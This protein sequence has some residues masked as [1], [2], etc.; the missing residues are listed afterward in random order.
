MFF[1]TPRSL[2]L[3]TLLTLT[4]TTLTLTTLTLPTHGATCNAGNP[5]SQPNPPTQ[6]MSPPFTS[7]MCFANLESPPF[8]PPPFPSVAAST[9]TSYSAHGYPTL[10]PTAGT[11]AGFFTPTANPFPSI[12]YFPNIVGSTS[13]TS[14]VSFFSSSYSGLCAAADT[15]ANGFRDLLYVTS[16]SSSQLFASFN[17]QGFAS[18]PPPPG[19][20]AFNLYDPNQ[21]PSPPPQPTGTVI[22]L[23]IVG[24]GSVANAVRD[25]VTD[26][27]LDRDTN[28]DL[29]VLGLLSGP[30]AIFNTA[31]SGILPSSPGKQAVRLLAPLGMGGISLNGS[32]APPSDLAYSAMAAGNANNDMIVDLFLASTPSSHPHS[33]LLFLGTPTPPS[34]PHAS[35]VPYSLAPPLVIAPTKDQTLSTISL[36]RVVFLDLNND[37]V[38]DFVT[39]SPPATYTSLPSSLPPIVTQ[40]RPPSSAHNPANYA[41]IYEMNRISSSASIPTLGPVSSPGSRL[42]LLARIGNDLAQYYLNP[43]NGR[44]SSGRVASGWTSP[45]SPSP[46]GGGPPSFFNTYL[47]S[48]DTNGDGGIDYITRTSD[49]GPPAG[50]FPGFQSLSLQYPQRFDFGSTV[51]IESFSSS[52]NDIKVVDLNSDAFLDILYVRYN[53]LYLARGTESGTFLSPLSVTLDGLTIIPRVPE[54]L[55]MDGDGRLDLVSV[56]TSASPTTLSVWKPLVP[57][58]TVYARTLFTVPYDVDSVRLADVDGDTLPDLV[59]FS[60]LDTPFPTLSWISSPYISSPGTPLAGHNVSASLSPAALSALASLPANIDAFQDIHPLPDIETGITSFVVTTTTSDDVHVVSFVFNKLG[61]VNV[62]YSPPT[63]V[64]QIP[65]AKTMIMDAD[66]DGEWDIVGVSHYTGDVNVVVG[67]SGNTTSW[68]NSPSQLFGFGPKLYPAFHSVGDLTGDSFPDFVVSYGTTMSTGPE[69]PT[70]YVVINSGAPRGDHGSDRFTDVAVVE[71]GRV[72]VQANEFAQN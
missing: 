72:I 21:P 36:S 69:S 11:G 61:S 63:P 70:V 38:L 8:S 66:Q 20:Y 53:K 41:G 59:A 14:A 55:D 33:V 65:L 64:S 57:S 4:L 25:I 71:T 7:N 60:S 49:S 47:G 52:V 43:G 40:S 23:P 29:I 19:S 13:R 18:P 26:I 17:T 32:Q 30:H 6:S 45:P 22:S 28:G 35:P 54:I 5:P 2:T 10:P 31:G 58:V 68:L 34:P 51:N 12:Q 24:D 67:Y 1:S 9:M 39:D 37:G 15:N 50:G 42:P 44:F 46:P 62:M 3:F 56:P 27:D 48:A 16:S